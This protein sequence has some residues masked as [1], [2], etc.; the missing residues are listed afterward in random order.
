MS[1]TRHRTLEM[2]RLTARGAVDVR[3]PGQLGPTCGHGTFSDGIVLRDLPKHSSGRPGPEVDGDDEH[4]TGRKKGGVALHR[5]ERIWEVVQ[6]FV[7]DDGV[8]RLVRFIR[9]G[10]RSLERRAVIRFSRG[11]ENRLFV[12]VNSDV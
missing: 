4:P 11:A 3:Y 9:V 1:L 2:Q 6:H 8:W 10:G 7:E 5:L 12:R